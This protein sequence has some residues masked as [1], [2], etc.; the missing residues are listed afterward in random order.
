[1]LGHHKLNINKN[2]SEAVSGVIIVIEVA[3][4]VYSN[5]KA[6]CLITFNI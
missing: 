6:A 2:Y 4:T 3:F 1:M 5:R